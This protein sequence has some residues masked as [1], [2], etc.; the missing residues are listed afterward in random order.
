VDGLHFHAGDPFS[1]AEALHR[2]VDLPDLWKTL[3]DGIAEIYDIDDAV[4]TMSEI[5]RRLLVERATA[6]LGA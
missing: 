6:T 3:H 4:K 1:L 5:Y 2:A